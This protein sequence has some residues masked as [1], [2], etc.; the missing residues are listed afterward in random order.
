MRDGHHPD[1]AVSLVES[2]EPDVPAPSARMAPKQTDRK[3]DE[4]DEAQD[5]RDGSGRGRKSAETQQA[6]DKR[7]QQKDQHPVQHHPL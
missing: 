7:P 2:T 6:G 1:L 3:E 5:L 4:Q